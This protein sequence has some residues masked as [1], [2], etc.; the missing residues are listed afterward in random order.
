[1]RPGSYTEL[2]FLDEATA[3][4]AGHR[5]C[6]ECRHTDYR[7]FVDA[8][9]IAFPDRAA[10]ADAIDAQ[11]HAERRAGPWTKRTFVAPVDSLPSGAFVALDQAYFLVLGR[12][13]LRWSPGGYVERKAS[14]ARQEVTVLT[15]PSV[16][17]AFR[18]GYEPA[19]H[20]STTAVSGP[21]LR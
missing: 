9:R 20:P 2:F 5:P 13:L 14:S 1:M 3:F 7:R 11:L 16:L 8:W 12:S 17:D 6:A 19:L 4:A 15:P 10:R 18:A 21:S